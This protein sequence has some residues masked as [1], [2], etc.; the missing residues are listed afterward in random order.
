MRN[1]PPRSREM[2]SGESVMKVIQRVGAGAAGRRLYTESHG[3]LGRPR[4]V[5]SVDWRAAGAGLARGRQR[6]GRFD[7]VREARVDEAQLAL[8]AVA[9]PI[10]PHFLPVAP[11][12]RAGDLLGRP[13]PGMFSTSSSEIPSTRPCGQGPAGASAPA[14]RLPSG[15]SG[16]ACRD[17]RDP[18]RHLRLPARARHRLDRPWRRR[19][20]TCRC[21]RRW[22]RAPPGRGM[23]LAR[24]H[25][26]TP[27]YC[28]RR[29]RQR[30][31][32]ML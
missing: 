10:A 15:S 28:A 31:P 13:Q 7:D 2:V 23:R 17:A 20:R 27:T 1:T 24:A 11:D 21:R 29:R 22:R 32:V 16:A 8:A 3:R 5:E 30:G 4:R 19:R 14:E 6:R 9:V 25:P 26:R 18:E 12:P